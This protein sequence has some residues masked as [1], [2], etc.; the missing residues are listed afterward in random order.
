MPV[1]PSR[2]APSAAAALEDRELPDAELLEQLERLLVAEAELV[3]HVGVAGERDRAARVEDH[4]Q[5]R[6]R[7]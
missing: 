4:L 6:A 1:R 5:V 7:G 3:G 2:S